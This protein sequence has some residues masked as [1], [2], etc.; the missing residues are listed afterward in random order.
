M[1][2]KVTNYPVPA[3]NIPQIFGDVDR[4]IQC[5]GLTQVTQHLLQCQARTQAIAVGVFGLDDN[6][7]VGRLD[8]L[9][10]GIKHIVIITDEGL[11]YRRIFACVCLGSGLMLLSAYV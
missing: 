7:I 8:E 9:L 1:G 11:A 6:D 4:A 2:W 5:H 10:G 3:A